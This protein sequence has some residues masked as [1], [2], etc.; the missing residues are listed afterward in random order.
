MLTRLGGGP[1][2]VS[3]STGSNTKLSQFFGPGKNSMSSSQPIMCKPKRIR[4]AQEGC[5]S[6]R[7]EI[8]QRSQRRLAGIAF[9]FPENQWRIFQQ[10]PNLPENFSGKELCTATAFSSFLREPTQFS[11]EATEFA[12]EFSEFSLPKQCSRKIIPPIPQIGNPWL[13]W[14]SFEVFSG[15]SLKWTISQKLILNVLFSRENRLKIS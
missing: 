10:R 1:N 2:T 6:L 9:V 15:Y 11:A 5:G 4:E 3:E 8:Q 14:G 7:G 13:F 12:A